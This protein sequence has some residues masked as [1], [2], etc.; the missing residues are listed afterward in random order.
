MAVEVRGAMFEKGVNSL[1]NVVAVDDLCELGGLD[2]KTFVDREIDAAR[3]ARK[4]GAD[5]DRRFADDGDG[6]LTRARQQPG[7][8]NDF[9]G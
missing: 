3:D 7:R 9:I 4:A 5:S 8:W 6:K 2:G 1:A